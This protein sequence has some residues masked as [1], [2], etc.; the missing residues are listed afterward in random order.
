MTPGYL[1]TLRQMHR[2]GTSDLE[3][4]SLNTLNA[5]NAH[6][7][8]GSDAKKTAVS[9]CE[10]A[11]FL[12]RSEGSL[13]TTTRAKSAISAISPSPYRREFDALER[14]CPELIEPERWKQ[15]VEDSRQ[16]LATWGNQAQALR[17]TAQELFGLHPV[18][19]K[20]YPSFQ[21]LARYDSTGLVWLLHGRPVLKMTANSAAIRTAS[22]GSVVY[23]KDNKPALGPLGDSLD[24]MG[25]AT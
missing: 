20:P 19:A 4:N 18:P 15:A 12:E 11:D 13:Q 3:S 2:T 25:S 21:R 1:K 14:F 5:L 7:P 22:G 9:E 6:A 10:N 17:W 16:F 24:D 23:R 8:T